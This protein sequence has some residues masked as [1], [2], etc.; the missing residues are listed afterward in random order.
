MVRNLFTIN[1]VFKGEVAGPSKKSTFVLSPEA[2]RDLRKLKAD[3]EYE[4]LYATQEGIVDELI[5]R[6]DLDLLRSAFF[7]VRPKARRYA[8]SRTDN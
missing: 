8:S 1:L 3:L 6:A 2:R 7:K 5:R 4:G